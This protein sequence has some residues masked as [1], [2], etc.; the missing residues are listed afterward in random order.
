MVEGQSQWQSLLTSADD[1]PALVSGDGEGHLP[2]GGPPIALAPA[3]TSASGGHARTPWRAW[4]TALQD[5]EETEG[6]CRKPTW[7]P[8]PSPCT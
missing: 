4:G 7:P 1:Q 8:H 6:E 2:T 3:S 5:R